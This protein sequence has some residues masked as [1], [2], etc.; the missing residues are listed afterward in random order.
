MHS[1]SCGWNQSSMEGPSTRRRAELWLASCWWSLGAEGLAASSFLFGMGR[2]AG[3]TV[4]ILTIWTV[5]PAKHPD[6]V[7]EISLSYSPMSGS[8]VI[9]K[10]FKR[11]IV[12]SF[13]FFLLRKWRCRGINVALFL[14][15]STGMYESPFLFPYD[16]TINNTPILKRWVSICFFLW[17]EKTSTSYFPGLNS[18]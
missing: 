3:E 13:S 10:S 15:P 8:W 9:K 16:V 11:C 6:N 4:R 18:A 14:V 5:F 1:I 2:G 17:R 7:P 12:D